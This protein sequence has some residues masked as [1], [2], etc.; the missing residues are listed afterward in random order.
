[1][2]EGRHLLLVVLTRT[3]VRHV[4][5]RCRVTVGAVYNW[6]AGRNS[7]GPRARRALLLSYGIPPESW[8]RC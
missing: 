4:A 2:T 5:L 8:R 6:L 1:M 7:P 3:S